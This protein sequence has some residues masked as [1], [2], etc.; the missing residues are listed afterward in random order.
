M[1]RL[2]TYQAL[3]H[4]GRLH[5][6]HSLRL[7]FALHTHEKTRSPS[8]PACVSSVSAQSE[9]SAQHSLPKIRSPSAS[10]SFSSASAQPE[11]GVPPPNL[12]HVSDIDTIFS[13][14]ERT[15]HSFQKYADGPH[16]L[17]WGKQPNPFRRYQGLSQVPLRHYPL[18]MS[19]PDQM[20]YPKAFTGF[21]NVNILTKAAV[22]QLFYDSC[23]LS[24]WKKA[25]D[26]LW[27]LRI[28]PSSGNLHPTEVYFISGTMLGIHSKPFVAH[29]C[30]KEHAF[31]IRGEIPYDLW[32]EMK[33]D[34]P[35]DVVFIGLTS[36]HW[37]E[38]WKYGERAFRYCNHDIGHILA[39]I[40]M[41]GTA[42]GWD[43][44]LV[45]GW[46]ND[47]LDRLLGVHDRQKIQPGSPQKGNYPELEQEHAV[48]L[49]ACF[50]G[51]RTVN[52][53][54]RSTT[55]PIGEITGGIVPSEVVAQ[56]VGSRMS[57]ANWQGRA[58]QLSTDHVWWEIIDKVAA[59][60]RK[61]TSPIPV[62]TKPVPL[63]TG[64]TCI[65]K[66]Y[67]LREVIIRRRSALNMDKKHVLSMDAFYQ[68]MSKALPSGPG[69]EGQGETAQFPFRV[70][71]WD[72]EVHMAIFVHK[73][74][75][76]S[77]GLYF[78][79]RNS[80]HEQKLRQVL[81]QDFTW[82]KPDKCPS[83]L[84]LY[85]LAEADCEKLAT[86]LSC[87]QEIAGA[88]CFTVGMIG[89]MDTIKEKGAWMYPRLH[90]ECGVLGQLLYL[91][92]HAF[93]VSATGIGCYF[94]DP[95]HDVLGLKTKEFQSLYLL[96]VGAAV[97]DKRIAGLPPYPAPKPK[98]AKA[99]EP[100]P[101]K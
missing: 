61:P 15:K 91:E 59:A 82:Y 33:R 60:S 96:S 7:P 45:D 23:A 44:I 64:L 55:E 10:A 80:E 85:R 70:L 79:V 77:K 97:E 98:D 19:P 52:W 46:G 28:N 27:S 21:I 76:L 34:L 42:I 39:A 13:Y 95:V 36:I 47:D 25:G 90:W 71:P 84:P 30:P 8:S 75:G 93:G 51:K 37:R 72:A 48:C 69:A 29:Y 94:D 4:A 83:T 92:A 26:A 62:F 35:N 68:I 9:L 99:P 101:F 20:A 5:R 22:S 58:N 100:P 66:P 81:R 32:V 67:T 2:K 18:Y 78:L 86:Q 56:T 54:F 43:A 73:V 88:G 89:R 24:A 16:G 87:F 57:Q 14:H 65:Y 38:A 12:S 6:W 41:A 11:L 49:V 50:P 31:E 74:A 63:Q 3:G 17:D 40:S 53:G 1:L